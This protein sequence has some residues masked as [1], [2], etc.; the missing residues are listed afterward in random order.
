MRRAAVLGHP[1]GHSLSPT[2]HSAAY[3]ALGIDWA[4][5]AIDTHEDQL[6]GF[7]AS[8]DDSWGGLSLTM[9]LKVEALRVADSVESQAKVVGAAN[10][11]V[12]AGKGEY[13]RWVAANTDVH[14]IAAAFREAGVGE[15]RGATILGGGATATS[16]VAAL[17]Q[18]GA[19][20]ITVA[21][22]SRARAAGLMRAASRMG[23]SVRFAQ[24]DGEDTLGALASADAVV[25]TIPAGA[26]SG[27]GE[28]LRAH[29]AAARGTLLDAIYDPPHTPLAQAWESSG[30]ASVGGH[31]ML[32]HQAA[33]QVKLM[34]G[35]EPPV[36]EMSHA[37]E[38]TLAAEG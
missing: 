5:E 18:L 30:G 33:A 21:V 15:V 8:L 31:R 35:H 25:S 10:T 27:V 2:L 16:A 11:L 22:R 37:I 4:Y 36:S 14:G 24:I 17:A 1:I 9:P 20:H 32:I 28:R 3:A 13:R 6:A 38:S 23:V 34:T 19:S 7:V 29:G 26:G 12:P